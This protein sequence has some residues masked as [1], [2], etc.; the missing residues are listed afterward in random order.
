M[1]GGLEEAATA[2]Q[3]REDGEGKQR[4]GQGG[5][6]NLVTHKSVACQREKKQ[7]TVKL[8][9]GRSFFLFW[10]VDVTANEGEGSRKREEEKKGRG[11][12]R[13]LPLE[14]K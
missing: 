2:R 5:A 1:R 6:A 13:G 3:R 8:K 7:T 11:E 12:Q 9:L 14:D 4:G 10:R